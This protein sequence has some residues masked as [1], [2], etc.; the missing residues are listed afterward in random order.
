MRRDKI[1]TFYGL[2]KKRIKNDSK[3]VKKTKHI[4]SLL[5]NI[6]KVVGGNSTLA[7]I[8]HVN[9]GTLRHYIN[10]DRFKKLP[11]S[12]MQNLTEFVKRNIICYTF[13]E[14]E[15]ENKILAYRV[16]HGKKVIPEFQD[17]RKI[18]I[19]VTPEFESIIFH[20]M[21]DGHVRKIGSGEYTQLNKIGRED[22][23]LKL[24]RTFGY[25]KISKKSFND[26]RVIIPKIII[27][28]ICKYYNLSY[29]SFRWDKANLPDIVFLRDNDFK[30][31]GLIAFIVD[32]GNISNNQISIASGNKELLSQIRIL[33]I[34]LGLE[35]SDLHF[36]KGT[37]NT[38]DS[39]RFSI[40]RRNLSRLMGMIENLKERYPTCSLSQKTQRV[41]RAINR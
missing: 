2:T 39:F 6:R 14:K 23:L 18:P 32:E 15:L 24:Y 31:A 22:F 9:P 11:R 34:D 36:K 35:C 1:I 28:I 13:T 4:I 38:T 26:G 12:M 21:G 25:F 8:I 40:Y 17:Q 29:D 16:A 30:L 20:L 7:R 41:L 33:T 5:K 10:N 37:G 19:R 3:R 27:K